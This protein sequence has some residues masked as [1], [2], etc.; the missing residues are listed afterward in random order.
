MQTVLP[1]ILKGGDSFGMHSSI[2]R[3]SGDNCFEYRWAHSTLA[4]HGHRF[5]LQCPKCHRL[6]S[7]ARSSVTKGAVEF[8]CTGKDNGV[9]CSCLLELKELV[10]FQELKVEH[11]QA[12]WMVSK[13]DISS[14]EIAVNKF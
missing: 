6:R 5:P 9:T 14:M 3:I 1:G 11:P 13:V 10:G 8:T 4:P 7:F 2:I 12:R